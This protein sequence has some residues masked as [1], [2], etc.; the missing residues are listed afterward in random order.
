MTGEPAVPEALALTGIIKTFGASRALDGASL[1]VR[2]GEIHGL[3]GQN[4]AGKSTIIKVLA[5]LYRP[6]D[7]TVAIGGE[8]LSHVTPRSVEARGV[9]IIHQEPLLPPGFTVAEALFLGREPRF[10]PLLA[11]RRMRRDAERIIAE[12]FG[13]TIPGAA[14]VSELSAA[15]RQVVQITRAL[16]E[17]PCVLVFDEPT[18]ALVRQEAHRLFAII[19]RLA[20]QGTA[21][22]YISHYLEEV[23]DLCDR[24]TILRNGRDVG[25]VDPRKTPMAEMVA[26]MINRDID[27]MFPKRAV[28][29]GA[30]VVELRNLSQTGGF[31][32][33]NLTLHAGEIVGLTGLLGSGAKEVVR[34]LFGLGPVN[35]GQI[36]LRGEP[37]SIP[38]PG[39]AVARRFGLV[40]EDRRHQGI[41]PDISLRENVTLA[42][43]S[44][45][46]RFGFING[47][48][49]TQQV[50][51]LID[52]LGI[53]T[54]GTE[55]RLRDL[56]GGN[57]QKVVLAK[58]LS[59]DSDVYILDEPTVAVDVAAKV[60]IY[61]L[62]GELAAR[63]A[64]I[65]VLSTD[66][67][68][69]R[70]ICDRIL[71]MYRGRITQRL[72]PTE[73]SADDILAAVT[74][75]DRASSVGEAA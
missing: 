61:R 75:A 20:A 68:E 2:R 26:R 12:Q 24:V 13:I 64:A 66:L 33:V 14:L 6:D 74:G 19:R 18:A 60:E 71:V 62:L 7:G 3:I 50:L 44:R 11:T 28:V 65:L 38:S 48:R 22:V 46:T 63:G 4:G 21:I 54:P 30:A 55:T 10:G 41:A 51:G 40:P 29:Q 58:W 25:T 1:V 73:A 35:A 16:L 37:V 57:Q 70:G 27:A 32:D 42:S 31:Q 23:R 59:A 49:E 5:G 53:K 69:L 17:A 15:E 47:R 9:Y 67:M 56:S 8:R 72:P 52:R 45:F 34:A 39:R 43:L 36:V